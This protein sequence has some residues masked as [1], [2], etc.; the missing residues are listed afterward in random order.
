GAWVGAQAGY[1]LSSKHWPDF[2]PNYGFDVDGWLGGVTTGANVQAGVFVVGAESE[3]LY[4]NMNGGRLDTQNFGGITQSTGLAS[5]VDWLWLNSVRAGF[6]FA[7]KW[8]VY[9]KGGV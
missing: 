8:M 7:D 3:W 5:R 1:G 2:F 4:A 6:V 9:A